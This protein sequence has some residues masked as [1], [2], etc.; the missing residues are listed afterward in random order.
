M[1]R[2]R[3]RRPGLGW[4]E[5]QL[6]RIC[7]LADVCRI[8]GHAVD[9]RQ[10]SDNLPPASKPFH[11]SARRPRLRSIL[12]RPGRRGLQ[13]ENSEKAYGLSYRPYLTANA[14]EIPHFEIGGNRGERR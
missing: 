6:E 8:I 13:A 5:P 3:G 9:S 4:P 11:A 1:I 14:E 10:A 2:D 12:R 7:G